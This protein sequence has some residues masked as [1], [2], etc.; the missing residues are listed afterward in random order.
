M[1]LLKKA[2]I[3][4]IVSFIIVVLVV[5]LLVYLIKNG[6]S[7]QDAVKDMLSLFGAGAGKK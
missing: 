7:I 1:N 6:W 5:I 4:G 3:P 2:R